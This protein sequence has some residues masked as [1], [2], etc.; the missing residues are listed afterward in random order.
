MVN[1]SSR[2]L[3]TETQRSHSAAYAATKNKER[4][5]T[6]FWQYVFG[7]KQSRRRVMKRFLER[8]HGRITGTLSGFDRVLF[9]GTLRSIAYVS[10]LEVFLYSQHV[11]FK[12]FGAYAESLSQRV[13]EHAKQTASQLNRPYQ[14]L[15]SS[16]DS[17]EELALRTASRLI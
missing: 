2:S 15:P 1:P 6:T 11:L 3:T 4:F 8:H 5:M 12:D 16:K 17:K 13:V 14:Y 9:R 7:N 10:G